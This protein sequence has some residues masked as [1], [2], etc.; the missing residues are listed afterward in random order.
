MGRW[1]Y[2]NMVDEFHECMLDVRS[3]LRA[4]VKGQIAA[5][6]SLLVNTDRFY[7]KILM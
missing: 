6:L 1:Q 3:G 7:G 4:S 5:V 2:V